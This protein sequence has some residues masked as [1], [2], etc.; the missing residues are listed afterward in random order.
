MLGELA[1]QCAGGHDRP[2]RHQQ[3][4]IRVIAADP[5]LDAELIGMDTF[6]ALPIL[7]SRP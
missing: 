6:A 2:H 4:L 5:L 7:I 1:D 3:Q